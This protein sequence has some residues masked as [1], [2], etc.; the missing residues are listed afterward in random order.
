MVSPVR[1]RRCSLS[2][3]TQPLEHDRANCRNAMLESYARSSAANRRAGR[4][5][6]AGRLL[7]DAVQA[8]RTATGRTAPEAKSM[9]DQRLREY[10]VSD[11]ESKLWRGM[12]EGIKSVRLLSYLLVG[13]K[14]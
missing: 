8:L 3:E 4:H 7:F 14:I 5:W 10:R 13:P 1:R 12:K 2:I 6:E 11:A 9:I